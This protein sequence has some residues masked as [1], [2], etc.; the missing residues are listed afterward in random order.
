MVT[1]LVLA[2]E[3]AAGGMA[4]AQ[5][6]IYPRK[7]I[8][9][10][11]PYAPGG[12]ADILS[13][14]IGLR[15]NEAWKQPVIVDNRPGGN[16]IIGAE[17]VAK[18]Q[19]DGYTLLVTYVGTLAINPSLYEKL[20]YDPPRDFA[21]ITMI[22]TLPLILVVTPSL[23]VN[24]VKDLIALAKSQPGKLTYSSGGVGQGSH[25]AAE[26]FQTV[27]GTKMTHVPYK[28]NAPAVADVVGGHISMIFDGMSSSLPHVR[29]GRLKA[30]GVTTAKRSASIPELNTIEEAG[31]PGFDV[32][33]WVGLLA[34][35]GA[36]KPIIAMLNREVARILELPE[37]RE[38]LFAMGHE[39]QTTTPDEFYAYLKSEIN[40]WAKVVKDS[41]AKAE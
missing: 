41:G 14:L 38:R 8:R 12:P 34:T 16:T 31:V 36:P 22:A 4:L 26:L 20:P 13:R 39:L 7:P 1:F 9:I 15:L 25:L 40:R 11:V 18:A 29:S 32:G 3:I 30:L 35:A 19:P 28:G 33:S 5:T 24:S 27:T 6:N 17:L 23:P 10:V 2:S 37:S 21:P